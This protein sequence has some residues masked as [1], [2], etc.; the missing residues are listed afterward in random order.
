MPHCARAVRS[1]LESLRNLCSEPQ[2]E[3]AKTRLANLVTAFETTAV[4]ALVEP[5][6]RRIDPCSD[7]LSLHLYQREL[8]F[9]LGVELR[10]FALVD[11]LTLVEP[12][13]RASRI[14]PWTSRVNS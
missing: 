14:L 11:H 7:G 10:G 3:G 6:Q 2:R 12:S 5:S 13:T 1:V 9:V 8:E 4:G